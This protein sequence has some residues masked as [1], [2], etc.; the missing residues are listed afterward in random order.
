MKTLLNL[1]GSYFFD[2]FNIHHFPSSGTLDEAIAATTPILDK[3]TSPKPLWITETSTT[4]MYFETRHRD[5]EEYRKSIHLVQTYTQAIGLHQAQC[6]FW[7]GLKNF[8][9][10][11]TTNRDTDFGLMT[12]ENTPLPA[13]T[14]HQVWSNLLMDSIPEGKL[15]TGGRI[16]VY[17]FRKL[18]T[19]ILVLWSDE[20]RVVFTLPSPYK[21]GRVTTL[22]GET[23]NVDD[24]IELGKEPLYLELFSN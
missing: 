7:C 6:I 9:K 18:K 17:Q 22:L 24:S 11:A 15:D 20:D 4:S 14:A 5:Y 23:H 13:Y 3:F 19:P 12:P 10:I 2:I 1:G 21:R 16:H 8:K